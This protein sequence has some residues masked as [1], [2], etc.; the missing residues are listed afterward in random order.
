M[1]YQMLRENKILTKSDIRTREALRRLSSYL[2]TDYGSPNYTL[3]Q[4]PILDIETLW[5]SFPEIEQIRNLYYLTEQSDI[6]HPNP[7]L[8]LL[9]TQL[10]VTR[11]STVRNISGGVEY[12]PCTDLALKMQILTKAA[13]LRSEGSARDIANYVYATTGLVNPD[14]GMIITPG[15]ITRR[16]TD[17][18]FR[19]T[20]ATAS[21][22]HYPAFSIDLLQANQYGIDIE[23]FIKGIN[24]IKPAGV[25]FN[26]VTF[27]CDTA[28]LQALAKG[29]L[30]L[31]MDS[32]PQEF[33]PLA[34]ANVDV[35]SL[36]WDTR[37]SVSEWHNAPW[38]NTKRGYKENLSV[39]FVF[40]GTSPDIGASPGVSSYYLNITSTAHVKCSTGPH[41]QVSYLIPPFT[42]TV[43]PIMSDYVGWGDVHW[44]TAGWGDC[45]ETPVQM[46][47]IHPEI[48][49]GINRWQRPEIS[50][51]GAH[52]LIPFNSVPYNTGGWNSDHTTVEH[53][54]ESRVW[55]DITYHTPTLW[56]TADKPARYILCHLTPE[57]R[58]VNQIT[59]DAFYDVEEIGEI[60]LS[61]ES[62]VTLF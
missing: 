59:L 33:I 3:L 51:T 49:T 4:A 28:E 13:T 34:G 20:D 10:G 7:Y 55:L 38:P 39:L 24:E 5:Q 15:N 29:Y 36:G 12:T 45:E 47:F 8:D 43:S 27:Q 9:A 30:I 53:T 6:P 57:Q 50:V 48:T 25:Y 60:M 52:P 31:Y 42:T 41:A 61:V 16:Y 17:Q 2:Q 58:A 46:M 62:E 11:V 1:H 40:T 37:W 21:D 19:I 23:Y 18:Q 26:G 54:N 35:W 22:P 56:V 32:G 14:T 44:H